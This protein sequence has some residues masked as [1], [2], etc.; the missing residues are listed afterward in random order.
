M[1]SPKQL[2]EQLPPRPVTR[3]APSPTGRLHLGHVVNAVWTWG[4]ARAL[5][6]TVVLRMEDHDRGRCRAAFETGILDDLAWLGLRADHGETELRSGTP[7]EFRQSDIPVRYEE[8]LARI[9]SRTNVYGCACSR[10]LVAARTGA[11]GPEEEV[12]YDGHCA[13]LGLPAAPPN[14]VRVT[15]PDTMARFHDALLGPQQQHPA[16]QCGD[17]LV[18]ERNGSWTYQWCVVADDLA[19]GVDLVVRGEDLLASTGRQLLLGELLGAVAPP[20]YLHHPL[21]FGEDGRKLSKRDGATGI[22]ELREAGV[23]PESVLGEAARRS[24]LLAAPRMVHADE[25]PALFVADQQ[26]LI[27]R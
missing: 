20:H 18:R 12:T 26:L 5:G 22:R 14:G 24:G 23:A 2:L 21:L 8:A 17:L 7:C 16:R 6:G 27:P 15:L 1:V 13:T 9:A 10:K 4:V 11:A 19:H 3:F 25:L